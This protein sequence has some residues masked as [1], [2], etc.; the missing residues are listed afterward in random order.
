MNNIRTV[1]PIVRLSLGAGV[2]LL[3]TLGFI[4]WVNLSQA[5]ID[6]SGLLPRQ[7]SQ[8]EPVAPESYG[9]IDGILAVYRQKELSYTPAESSA[10]YESMEV[11]HAKNSER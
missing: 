7:V 9:T 3:L 10:G 1:S 6:F 5:N 4:A 8:T 11:Y 2:I